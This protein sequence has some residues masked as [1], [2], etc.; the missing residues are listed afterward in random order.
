MIA[1]AIHDNPANDDYPLETVIG[2]EPLSD[3]RHLQQQTE[4]AWYLTVA[5]NAIT[6]WTTEYLGLAPIT[7]DLG[8]ARSTRTCWPTPARPNR[9]HIGLFGTI[10]VDI[11]AELARLVPAGH[12]PLRYGQAVSTTSVGGSLT[13]HDVPTA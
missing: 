1:D 5:T 13:G 10:A 12:R 9:R 11:D 4:Q 7:C 8:A 3:R 6:T 2:W